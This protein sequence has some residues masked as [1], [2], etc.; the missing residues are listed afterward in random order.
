MAEVHGNRTHL[1]RRSA[2]HTGFEVQESHQCPIHFHSIKGF[3]HGEYRGHRTLFDIS[4][5]L[6]PLVKALGLVHAV[7]D[8]GRRHGC[9]GNR[10]H[11]RIE[12]YGL[13]NRP[14][15]KPLPHLL[16]FFFIPRK[17]IQ[18]RHLQ[19]EKIHNFPLFVESEN[20]MGRMADVAS[21]C[22]TNQL[23]E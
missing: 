19:R 3:S 4:F 14:A 8:Q 11:L 23:G 18:F 1:G 15:D 20:K 17:I 6:Q 9:R 10:V 7:H 12:V 5:A 22:S 16:Y 13:K 2:P 21:R